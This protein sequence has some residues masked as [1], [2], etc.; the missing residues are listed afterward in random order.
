ML[1]ESRPVALLVRKDTFAPHKL[2]KTVQTHYPMR[3]EQAIQALVD[4]LDDEDIIVS[5]TGKASRELYEYREAKGQG[6]DRDFL[7]V[8]S[9]GH[10]SSIAMGIAR[11]RPGKRTIC[12]DGDGAVLMHMGA[13]AIL[14]QSGLGNLVHVVINNGVHDSVGGQPTVGNAIDLPAIARACGYAQ[15]ASTDTAQGVVEAF[16]RFAHTPN[17]APVLL[18]VKVNKGARDDLGRPKTTPVQNRDAL[19]ARLDPAPR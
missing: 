12:I 4:L 1:A 9:M 10:A 17:A 11:S 16:T 6:H 19:M 8:G 18:E 15:V 13:M 7:T 14:G 3:R 2:Q 5:T